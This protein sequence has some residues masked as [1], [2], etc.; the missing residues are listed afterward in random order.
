M[1]LMKKKD[2]ERQTLLVKQTKII[3][4]TFSNNV[5]IQLQ[6]KKNQGKGKETKGEKKSLGEEN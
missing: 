4:K 3:T 2:A 5:R 6:I 1:V